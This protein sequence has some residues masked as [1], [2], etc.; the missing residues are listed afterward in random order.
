MPTDLSPDLK[1]LAEQANGPDRWCYYC[2]VYDPP[3]SQCR[4]RIAL[5]YDA[6]LAAE[7]R[8]EQQALRKA[9]DNLPMPDSIKTNW[10][11]VGFWLRQRAS[12]ADP[13]P[14]QEP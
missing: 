11:N 10:G 5:I 2:E 13:P 7:R 8:G 6:L 3:C 14:A 1:A 9:A 12:S 4:Q